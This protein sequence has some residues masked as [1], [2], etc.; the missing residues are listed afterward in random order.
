MKER[1]IALDNVEDALKIMAILIEN[2]YCTML[3]REEDFYIVSLE[4]ALNA[5]RNEVV[6][7]SREEYEDELFSFPTEDIDEA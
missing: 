5:N 3:S 6:F 7:N 1:I 2:N 4:F